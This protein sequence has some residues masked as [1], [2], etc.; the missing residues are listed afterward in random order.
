MFAREKPRLKLKRGK[1]R[2]FRRKSWRP[3]EISRRGWLI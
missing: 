2:K 3:K 1:W